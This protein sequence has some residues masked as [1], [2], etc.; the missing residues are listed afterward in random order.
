MFKEID[1]S[2][3]SDWQN[4]IRAY[5]RS[6]P[7]PLHN[8]CKSSVTVTGCKIQKK[9]QK[10]KLIVEKFRDTRSFLGF[11][12]MR[13]IQR[14]DYKH[15]QNYQ[16]IHLIK[17]TSHWMTGL[18]TIDRNLYLILSVAW[19]FQLGRTFPFLFW[20]RQDLHIVLLKRLEYWVKKSCEESDITIL[21]EESTTNTVN[22]PRKYAKGRWQDFCLWKC[23][24][25]LLQSPTQWT[26][27]FVVFW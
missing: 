26:L 25:L 12:L 4:N 24:L 1:F 13:T 11:R 5:T 2:L 17:L 27:L 9:I 6:E 8:I 20:C 22:M 19:W 16:Y 23:D 10:D 7:I 15:H 21:N 3:W 14:L 18:F